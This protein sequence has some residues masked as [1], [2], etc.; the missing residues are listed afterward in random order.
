M[1]TN[2]SPYKLCYLAVWVCHCPWAHWQYITSCRLCKSNI[3]WRNDE[4]VYANIILLTSSQIFALFRTNSLDASHS[5]EES[6]CYSLSLAFSG[7]SILQCT[8]IRL[9]RFHKRMI[10]N[11]IVMKSITTISSLMLLCRRQVML[12]MQKMD[13][14]ATRHQ[15]PSVVPICNLIAFYQMHHVSY[16]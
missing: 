4:Y 2:T 11:C 10:Y 14:L 13:S 3:M 6:D 5:W 1:A 7:Q 16:E 12:Y 9:N 8:Q 15:E